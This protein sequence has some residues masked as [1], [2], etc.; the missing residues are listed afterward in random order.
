MYV[1]GLQAELREAHYNREKELENLYNSE[2]YMYDEER[3]EASPTDA[4]HYYPE[5]RSYPSRQDRYELEE[6]YTFPL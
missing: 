4:G 3:Q 1:Y 5:T 6:R 2:S